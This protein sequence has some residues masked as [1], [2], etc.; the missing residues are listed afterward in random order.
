MASSHLLKTDWITKSIKKK[1]KQQT[2][3]LSLLHLFRSDSDF[4]GHLT[5]VCYHCLSHS[6]RHPSNVEQFKIIVA[7]W[8]KPNEDIVLC[9]I[10][11]QRW[12]SISLSKKLCLLMVFSGFLIDL[13]KSLFTVD[14]KE[15][16][17]S[18]L[19]ENINMYNSLWWQLTNVNIV[20]RTQCIPEVEIIIYSVER[21]LVKKYLN[22]IKYS[23]GNF[24]N[25]SNI[26]SEQP[27][28]WQWMCAVLICAQILVSLCHS[29]RFRTC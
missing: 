12:D 11:I 5:F 20:A 25:N 21:L 9:T 22:Y 28:K 15:E 6:Q 29:I 8:M 18:L 1:P 14:T 2:T 7:T 23:T 4:W 17:Q 16:N 24:I 3:Y 27:G 10:S 19:V 13:R 26:Y